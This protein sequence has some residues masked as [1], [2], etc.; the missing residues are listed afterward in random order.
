MTVKKNVMLERG[1]ENRFL[2]CDKYTFS[3]VKC[4]PSP[5]PL[6]AFL[7]TRGASR[8]VGYGGFGAG[9]G[10]VQGQGVGGKG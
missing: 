1:W 5:T 7:H 4:N 2:A 10:W 8:Q 3:T 6:A 9:G